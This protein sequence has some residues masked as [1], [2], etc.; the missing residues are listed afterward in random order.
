MK[1]DMELYDVI[2]IVTLINSLR[3]IIGVYM[4][5]LFFH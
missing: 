5:I 3:I 2:M 1:W 4:K